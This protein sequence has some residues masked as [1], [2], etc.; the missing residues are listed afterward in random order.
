MAIQ[1]SDCVSWR[2]LSNKVFTSFAMA[3]DLTQLFYDVACEIDSH[4]YE[5]IHDDESDE[6]LDLYQCFL[7]TSD[8]TLQELQRKFPTLP[9]VAINRHNLAE[10]DL[11]D[12]LPFDEDALPILQALQNGDDV[13]LIGVTH[14][15]TSWDYVTLEC[16]DKE[17]VDEYCK[18]TN[19]Q[20]IY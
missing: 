9:V 14:W 2:F 8:F 15:G 18:S 4:A 1:V 12:V 17:L 13:F 11:L 6:F 20:P 19:T 7:A 5:T 16:T 3:N 10:F